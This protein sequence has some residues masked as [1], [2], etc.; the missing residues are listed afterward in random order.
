MN[1]KK[2][3][4]AALVFLG[5]ATLSHA[6]TRCMAAPYPLQ[7]KQPDG[8]TITVVGHGHIDV[9]YAET[10]D[11]YTIIP[12]NKGVYE[13]AVPAT[14][15]G[16]VSSGL[17]ANDPE[18]RSYSE[19]VYLAGRDA[20]MRF[21]DEKI[22]KMLD[23]GSSAARDINNGT[24]HNEDQPVKG[25]FPQTGKRKVLLILMQYPDLK[26][27]YPASNYANLMNQSNY[28]GIG[29]FKDFY[30]KSSFG[31]L[32]IEAD[33]IGWF[34]APNGYA[35]Y[36]NS[37]G[38][39]RARELVA[40][41]IDSA[42]KAGIDF[43][44][45]DNDKNGEVDGVMVLHSGPGA[46]EGSQNQYIWSHRWSISP[47]KYDGVYIEDYAINPESRNFQSR[48]IGIG[49]LCHEFGH[50]LG[51]PDLYDVTY[52]SSGIGNWSLMAGGCWL[53]DENTPANNDAWS[54]IEL[55][56]IKPVTIE[57]A[58]YY[59][60]KPAANDSTVYK[61]LTPVS[62]E[63]FLLENRQKTGFDKQLPYKGMAIW[64]IDQA[65]LNVT[66]SSN[67]VNADKTR[68]GVD[69]EE[70]DGTNGLDD[71]NNRG[72]AGDLF[73]GFKMNTSFDD[74][75]KPNAKTYNGAN[76]GIRIFSIATLTDSSVKFGFGALPQATFTPSVTSVCEKM[77]IQFNNKSKF[78]TSYSW[79]FGDGSAADTTYSP[80]H[81][82]SKPGSYYVKLSAFDNGSMTQDSV[83]IIVNANAVADFDWSANGKVVSFTNKSQNVKQY[84][85]Y[86]GDG[87]TGYNSTASFTRSYYDT[88]NFTIK[89]VV[90]GNGGCNDTLVKTIRIESLTSGISDAGHSIGLR[91]FPN[92]A[93][94]RVMVEYTTGSTS[95]VKL[96]VLNSLGQVVSQPRA[97][98][99][100][101]GNNR[102]EVS[103]G[104]LNAGIYFVKLE[105]DGRAYFLSVAKK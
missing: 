25:S 42:E 65:V 47:K 49:V 23:N 5:T 67:S 53:D 100:S 21:S 59:I 30:L 55:G 14:D 69:L 36:A 16:L 38:K 80:K 27:K 87:K 60:L 104:G 1:H 43:S 93:D 7:V 97:L 4:L 48:M 66:L 99:S 57:A 26:A 8:T 85:W 71:P 15:G 52:A 64:H 75:T 22:A 101:V 44:K 63:F 39:G 40:S 24:G 41:A 70:A 79:N 76:S 91:A 3:L 90:I 31:K 92:P 94:D 6:Q 68:K 102:A 74:D 72:D 28:K 84:I 62:T 51:L 11:G 9:N 103:L 18:T 73:P 86:W 82:F 78:A 45:Y 96:T 10:V 88:G 95:N 46:E 34:T 83:K 2:S 13:Y 81:T 105:I 12:N 37:N 29:S 32:E 98:V 54:R 19:K 20:H 56:W 58:G 33:V 77:P 61:V 35:Y 89:L 50:L 17:K